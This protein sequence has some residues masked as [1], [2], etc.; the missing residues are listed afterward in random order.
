VSASG[1]RTSAVRRARRPPRPAWARRR[2]RSRARPKRDWVPIAAIAVAGLPGLAAF[3]ALIFSYQASKA[4]DT[5]L[6]IADTQL[7][8][9][10]RGQITDRYTAAIANL[11]SHSEDVRIG[12][13]YALQHLMQDSP[14][15]YQ[16][17]VIAVLCAFVRDHSTLPPT[18][19]EE[20]PPPGFQ[21][22][23]D[24]QAV[25]TVV[26]TRNIANDGHT[27][28]VDLDNTQLAGGRFVR[29]RL[30]HAD[31]AGADLEL[32]DLTRANL[33]SAN[34]VDAHLDDAILRRTDLDGA[35]LSSAELPFTTLTSANLEDAD[36]KFADLKGAA[37]NSADLRGAD[38]A[39]ANL[40]DANLKGANLTGANLFGALWPAHAAI[41]KG[42]LRDTHTGRLS[43]SGS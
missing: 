43:R 21:L 31:L 8:I 15:D 32:T 36:L 19:E 23:T 13:I 9:A 12:G 28:V 41:P 10:E 30:G 2:S 1:G 29:D 3:V 16:S 37:L 33:T 7:Q 4:T 38:L 26:G 18:Q 35:N 6:H 42:W 39:G 5:Q 17:T 24:I 20:P 40:T 11:G 34:L 14:R 22:A 25:V 27:T